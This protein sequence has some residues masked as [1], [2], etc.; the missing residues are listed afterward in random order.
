M[1]DLE[2]AIVLEDEVVVDE[3]EVTESADPIEDL[4]EEVVNED[5]DEEEVELDEEDEVDGEEEVELD[6]EVET[7]DDLI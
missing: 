1:G 5:A 7:E 2:N 4:T 3:L 6:E